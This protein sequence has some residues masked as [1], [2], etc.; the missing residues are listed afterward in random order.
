MFRWTVLFL[1][2]ALIAGV[3]SIVVAGAV[4]GMART[5]CFMF[6]VLVFVSYLS[7]ISSRQS[8]TW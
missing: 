8:W 1:I 2:V 3:D 6:L 4:A 7:S 5:L